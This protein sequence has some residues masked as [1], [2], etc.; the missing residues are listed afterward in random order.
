MRC[1]KFRCSTGKLRRSLGFRPQVEALNL[2]LL[3]GI[4]VLVGLIGLSLS[5][6]APSLQAADSSVTRNAGA[7]SAGAMSTMSAPT[8]QHGSFSRLPLRFEPNQGQVDSSAQFLARGNGYTLLLN[9]QEAVLSL[10]M[11]AHS[12]S[13]QKM[14][15][16]PTARHTAVHMQFIGANPAAQGIGLQPL[17]G[18]VTYVRGSDPSQWHAHIPTYGAIEYRDIYPGINIDY[19]SSHQ[20]WEFDFVVAPGSDPRT[21]ALNFTGASRVALDRQGNLVLD[22]AAGSVV[23][24][25]PTVYQIVEGVRQEI[26]AAFAMHGRQVGFDIGAYDTTR[27]L[28]ID[29]TVQYASYFDAGTGG[30]ATGWS[31]AVDTNGNIYLA[32]VA[33]DSSNNPQGFALEFDSTG[34]NRV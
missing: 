8:P 33:A 25:R 34:A 26:P 15:T 1:S 5:G 6:P 31:V 7:K 11:P 27:P 10:G 32:G 19:Y 4:A 29:P 3:L 22:T 20:Q 16:M 23:Q 18:K 28:V 17:P 14:P 13:S 30:D 21:I 2:R 9:P 12:G 24:H